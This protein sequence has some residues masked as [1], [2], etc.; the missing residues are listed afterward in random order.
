MYMIYFLNLWK[1]GKFFLVAWYS[2]ILRGGFH[3]SSLSSP[4]IILSTEQC[5]T[6]AI[7]N[8]HST[9]FQTL[10][11]WSYWCVWNW[12]EF[13]EWDY[14]CYSQKSPRKTRSSCHCTI[15]LLFCVRSRNSDYLKKLTDSTNTYGTLLYTRFLE[16]TTEQT[17][18]P[19]L[20]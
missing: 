14:W 8:D 15:L 11:N 6:G 12:A 2:S 19:F 18:L 17:S 10:D 3:L 4:S 9:A 20:S 16:Y 1:L 5:W 7:P 13:W